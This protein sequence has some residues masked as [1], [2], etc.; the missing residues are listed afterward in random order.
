[1]TVVVL[2]ECGAIKFV[3]NVADTSAF[4]KALMVDAPVQLIA[5]EET[6]H[7]LTVTVAPL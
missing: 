3:D 5:P 1:M 4:V 7:E 6:T 2:P